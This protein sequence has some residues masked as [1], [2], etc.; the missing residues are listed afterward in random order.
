MDKDFLHNIDNLAHIVSWQD[1]EL[2][3]DEILICECNC[4]NVG[5]IRKTLT[6]KEELNPKVLK[7][8]L[9]LGSG[10]NSCIK[11]LDSWMDKVFSI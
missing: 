7:E 6:G 1:Q 9:N 8:K 5:T 4:I 10:C 11:S 3:A 2:L